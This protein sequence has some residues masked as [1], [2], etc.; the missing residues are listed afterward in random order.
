MRTSKRPL[1]KTARRPASDA[2]ADG[3]QDTALDADRR[4]HI[5]FFENEEKQ[6]AAL[7]RQSPCAL[8]LHAVSLVSC[9]HK[10]NEN[11]ESQSAPQRSLIC[12]VNYPNCQWLMI[13]HRL[14]QYETLDSDPV[15][16]HNPFVL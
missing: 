1:L 14:T 2:T 13:A 7:K 9:H 6:S 11:E 5:N 15:A 12:A 16:R 10:K 3:P 8:Y 4:G